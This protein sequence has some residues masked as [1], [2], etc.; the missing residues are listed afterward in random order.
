[1]AGMMGIQ[2]QRV[3]T[4]WENTSQHK[5]AIICVWSCLILSEMNVDKLC[6][7]AFSR[8][9]ET[10]SRSQ[11][12]MRSRRWWR[13]AAIQ[14]VR[15]CTPQQCFQKQMM[16][17][18]Y[19]PD[20]AIWLIMIYEIRSCSSTPTDLQGSVGSAPSVKNAVACQKEVE[21][22]HRNFFRESEKWKTFQ[23][24]SK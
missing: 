4:R 21:T 11:G 2:I 24:S 20:E 22:R 14:D 23:N 18:D 10:R 6:W 13:W 5:R 17:D 19:G 15:F 9:A 1:M 16:E 8:L 7:V 3:F 12:R